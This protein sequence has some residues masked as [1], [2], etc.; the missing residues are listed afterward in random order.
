MRLKMQ[1]NMMAISLSPWPIILLISGQTNSGKTNK[2][3]NLL[4]R[5]KLYRMFD[6]K[7]AEPDTF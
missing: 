5:N 2:V 1:K 3:I 7:K 4:P 6:G